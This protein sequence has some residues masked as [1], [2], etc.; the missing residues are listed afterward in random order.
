MFQAIVAASGP[1]QFYRVLRGTTPVPPVLPYITSIVKTG[2]FFKITF[3]GPVSDPPT[4][5]TLLSSSVPMVV[6]NATAATITVKVNNCN[7]VVFF[8]PSQVAVDVASGTT[9]DT[10]SS[11]GYIFTYTRDKLFT[12]GVGM[13]EP[14]GRPVV[15]N[16]PD[17]VEAQAITTGPVGDARI[18][19]ERED[20]GTFA[21][22]A[23]TGRL[24]G[25]T[26]ATGAAWEIMPKLNGEDGL[27][28]PVTLDASGMYGSDFSYDTTANPWG[29]TALL[30]GFDSYTMTL[31]VDFA[32]VGLTLECQQ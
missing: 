25:N 22:T 7:T 18:T 6:T 17:G 2:A 29:S 28:D 3:T 10:I 4:M 12:G 24:L 11:N 15:V 27:A 31:F 14:I 5:Y 32:I 26:A 16:W 1:K 8:D 19:I 13:T 9:S 21:I 30:T 23:I 20:G